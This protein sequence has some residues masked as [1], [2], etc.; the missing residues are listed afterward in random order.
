MNIDPHD[1]LRDA[2]STASPGRL[3]TYLQLVRIP[4]V[5]TAL[6]DVTMGYLLT[7]ESLAP[8][9][10]FAALAVA[11]A[12][13][14]MAGIVLN[15]VFDADVDARERPE[16]PIP[17]GRVSLRRAR[18]LG[19]EL[20]AIGVASGWLASALSGQV[21]CGVVATLLAIAVVAYDAVLKRTSLGPLAM[22]SCRFLNVLLG[23]SAA[24][25]MWHQVHWSVAA[26]LGTYIAGVTWFARGEAEVSRRPQL[27]F[28]LMVMLAGMALLAALPGFADEQLAEVSRW[29]LSTTSWV[30]LIGLLGANIGWRCLQAILDPVPAKV[31]TAVKLSILS[32]IVL[33]GAVTL[34]VREPVWAVGVLALLVPAALLGTV[35][36]ST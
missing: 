1:G 11:S 23:A 31:Q 33:D 3:K 16:R 19:I 17:S 27:V 14:Y 21:A 28:A 32:L 26:G 8:W 7:H 6:A 20:L 10:V 15:D 22:G 35:I 18:W 34:A 30:L 2:P 25:A 29:R 5:F 24:A 13:L 36:Y 9:S 4:N 12:C